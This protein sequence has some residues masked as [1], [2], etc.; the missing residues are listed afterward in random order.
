MECVA[1]EHN[2][3]VDK[4]GTNISEIVFVL[5]YLQNTVELQSF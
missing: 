4:T 3:S 5:F 2:L 1:F